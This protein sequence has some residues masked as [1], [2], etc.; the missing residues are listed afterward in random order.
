MPL[1]ERCCQLPGMAPQNFAH[2]HT[3]VEVGGGKFA[4]Y[5]LVS[6]K[7]VDTYVRVKQNQNQICW[8]WKK[9]SFPA[10]TQPRAPM[11]LVLLQHLVQ[12]SLCSGPV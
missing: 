12:P 11:M 1:G 8:K 3:Q 7:C 9:V 10:T 6:C 5:E 4:H 2:T